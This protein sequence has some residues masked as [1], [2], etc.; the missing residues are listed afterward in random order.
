[1]LLPPDRLDATVAVRPTGRAE[2]TTQHIPAD[3]EHHDNARRGRNPQIQKNTRV[4]VNP[5]RVATNIAILPIVANIL[6]GAG[7]RAQKVLISA[8]GWM[9]LGWAVEAQE[10]RSAA[11]RVEVE[12]AAGPH[13]VGQG[14]ELGV[15]VVGAGRRPEVDPPAIVGA[16]VWLIRNN[17][18]RPISV[19]GIGSVV[20]ESNVFV[21]RYRIV[22]R[23]AGTLQIPS[24]RARLRDET[25]R[26]RPVQVTVHPV[27]PEGRPAE[28]LGGVGRFTLHAEANPQSVRVGQELEYRI[29]VDG[30]AAWGMTGRPEPKR[31][32]RLEVG[33]RIEPRPVEATN[34]PPSRTFVYTLRPSRPGEAV[35]PPVAIAAFDPSSRHYLTHVTPGV[36]IRVIAVP[37]FD[38]AT[39][40]D[41]G[42]SGGRGA[43]QTAM[44]QRAILGATVLLAG[45]AA[46]IV[47]V[48]RRTRL[49]GPVAA[50]RF[51]ARMARGLAHDAPGPPQELALRVA[52]A[53]IRYL[54]L[55]IGR[56]A[57]A[58]TPDEAR[59]GVARCTGSEELGEQAARIA[60][61][62]DGLLYRDAPAPP[63]DPG[64]LRDDA[65][66]LF[67]RL[68]SRS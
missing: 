59:E 41:L 26:S 60:A 47:W 23:R 22:P 2:H 25:G 35:L 51:A 21:S 28:F 33:L 42:T 52:S 18:L 20:G 3:Q 44:R 56:P 53:L 40:P 54:Q 38:T 57:G 29:T 65:R 8:M 30:P 43:G 13:Y 7:R 5:R 61:R 39:I 66:D 16:D 37:A 32:D 6:G 11:M 4:R 9:L 12:V 62:C 58:L 19:G 50:R 55:G 36:P 67:A 64:R 45:S 31:F 48:R 27:P 15:A 1:M 49:A 10:A 14:F 24:I 63:E 34:E 17:E 46:A 68:G